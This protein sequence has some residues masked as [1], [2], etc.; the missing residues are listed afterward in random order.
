MKFAIPFLILAR[1][2][3]VLMAGF[4]EALTMTP[5]SVRITLSSKEDNSHGD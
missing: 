4:L 2:A 3:L 1:A 5:N